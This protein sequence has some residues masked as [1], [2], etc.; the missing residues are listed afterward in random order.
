MHDN[1]H[2]ETVFSE[3]S[4]WGRW[5]VDDERG[6]L[7]LV[8]PEVVVQAT[9]LVTDGEL[10]ACGSM[11]LVATAANLSPPQHHMLM[12]GDTAPSG[13][14]QARDYIGIAP[15][16]PATTHLDALCH[17]FYDG[18]MYNDRPAGL[19]TSTGAQANSIDAVAG[20]VVT[21]GVL[22]DIPAV[23][24]VDFIEPAD[25]VHVEDLEAAEAAAGIRVRPGDAL[26]VRVGR[27]RRREVRGA[28]V[29]RLN[30]VTNMAGLDID[31]LPWLR[32]RGVALLGSDAA[33]DA[34]PSRFSK[35]RAPIHIGALVFLGLH[36]LDNARLD[37]LAETCA[38]KGRWE[39]LFTL[40]PLD[41]AGGTGS[42]VNPVAIF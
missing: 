2:I 32:D 24:N 27:H 6:T 19:I 40:A 36:L 37:V 22:L 23:R 18:R 26:M 14:G 3:I 33:H 42:P 35:A 28:G 38:T 41:I 5:G 16:G 9:S 39:F 20:G 8:S 31:C 30:G 29:E 11:D 17:V 13:Y 15:H 1:D 12:A 4:N 7:N 25:L 10:V 34:L 21:R